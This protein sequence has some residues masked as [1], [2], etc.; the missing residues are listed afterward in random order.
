MKKI[1]IISL[2][3]CY[4]Q[5][6]S[7]IIVIDPGHGYNSSGGN[8][9]GRT[10]IEHTTSLQTGLKLK[11]LIVNDCPNWTAYMTR[12]TANGWITLS[13][14]ASMSNS[15]NADYY[16]SIHCNAGGGTGTETFW[17]VSNDG[18]STDDV[19]FANEIQDEMVAGG[20]WFYRRCV[21]DASYIF[22][23]SVLANSNAT[24]CLNEI[25][26]VDSNDSTKLK[27]ATWQDAFAL[28]YK[29]ALENLEGSCTN[30]SSSDDCANSQELFSN[31]SCT[32]TLGTLQNATSSSIT[33]PSC[34]AFTGTPAMKDVFYYFI[35]TATTHT[36]EIDPLGTG[37]S[38]LD[39]VI[40][41]Y[42]GVNCNSLSEFDCA[43]VGTAGSIK[44][45]ALSGLSIGQKYWVRVYDYGTV[46]PANQQFNICLTHQ[47]SNVGIEDE[48]LQN[49]LIVFPNPSQAIFNVTLHNND[50]SYQYIITNSLGQSIKNGLLNKSNQIDLTNYPNGIY[51]L[52]VNDGRSTINYK[53]L[54]E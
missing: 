18:S 4:I 23:L 25:G 35:A 1:L 6:N 31:T 19:A 34:D 33:K 27:S 48:E 39:A 2:F 37:T 20:S 46:N 32:Y 36:V 22:H 8:P 28:S 38:G 17:C 29:M 52:T 40:A 24:G 13:Q 21:E 14:R 51:F 3:A 43:S 49:N 12:S 11:N 30:I 54:K 7:Q 15:W 10:Y 41:V 26:F 9:D 42:T 47:N 53:L 5:A 45:I 44:T 50:K 16:L